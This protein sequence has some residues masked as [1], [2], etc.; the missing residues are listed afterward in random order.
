MGLKK[1]KECSNEVSTDAESCPQCG[2]IL[3]NNMGCSK[4]LGACIIILFIFVI[5]RIF[6]TD[7]NFESNDSTPSTNS[8]LLNDSTK[9]K[10]EAD[11]PIAQIEPLR[12]SGDI[13]AEIKQELA[14]AIKEEGKDKRTLSEINSSQVLTKKPLIKFNEKSVK[15]IK[16]RTKIYAKPNKKSFLIGKAKKG[17]IF[18]LDEI[19]DEW[20]R[21]FMFS[22]EYRY[23]HKKR[24]KE[25]NE[26]PDLSKSDNELKKIFCDLVRAQD[27]ATYEAV[28]KYPNNL[29][30]QIYFERMLDDRYELVVC[31]KNKL[32]PSNYNDLNGEV[33]ARGWALSLIS[34]IPVYGNE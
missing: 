27:K 10:K 30:L 34:S 4:F 15:V 16:N 20:F 9:D 29:D 26:I 24:A 3:K 8:E 18:T 14:D 17:D 25:V 19:I 23:I 6:N 13:I 1:C 33:M 11:K 22:G 12:S 32:S 2:A 28:K 21:V 7:K 5:F 31:H